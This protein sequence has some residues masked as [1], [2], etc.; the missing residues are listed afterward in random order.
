MV[1]R[2]ALHADTLR[3]RPTPAVHGACGSFP[4]LCDDCDLGHSGS[5][6]HH[7]G[8]FRARGDRF[9]RAENLRRRSVG[10]ESC[11]GRYHVFHRKQHE[12]ACGHLERS[13]RLLASHVYI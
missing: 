6:R 13:H 5:S 10:P 12:A 2:V 1:S 9:R 3:P 4:G 11:Y 8:R 7:I